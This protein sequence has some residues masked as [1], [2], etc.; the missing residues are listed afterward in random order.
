MIHYL[1]I[2]NFGPI[3]K[4]VVLDFEVSEKDESTAYEVTMPD[5]TRVLKLIY[6]YG[7]NASGKTTFLKA[8]SFLRRLFLRPVADKVQELDYSPFLFTKSPQHATT[9]FE[10]SFYIGMRYVY[11]LEL[12][13]SVITREKMIYYAS[14][15][16]TVLFERETDKTKKLTSLTFGSAIKVAAKD[17]DLLEGNT[18]HNNSVIGAFGKTNVDIPSLAIVYAYFSKFLAGVLDKTDDLIEYTAD[19]ISGD[20]N[21]KS[22]VNE[23]MHK[24]D[25]QIAAVEA[26]EGYVSVPD[27]KWDM[28]SLRY[29]T[30]YGSVRNLFGRSNA[31][32]MYG[33]GS[34]ERKVEVKHKVKDV[35]YT[36]PLSSESSGTRHYFGLA[37]P[38]YKLIHGKQILCIDELENSLHPDLMQH[39]LQLFLLNASASQLVITTHNLSLM[40]N[41]DLIR[42]DALWF[43]QKGDD[44]SVQLYSAADFDSSVLRKSSSILKAYNTGKLGAK[45]NLGSPYLGWQA[46]LDDGKKK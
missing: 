25:R 17:R 5:G 41:E 21:I 6:L 8:F 34:V 20:S 9:K 42:K 39:F 40:A 46:P 7:P 18:L 13:N 26:H 28:T 1:K 44:G 37:G 45:P 38:L 24:A 11:E 2:S 36:L 35:E 10:L 33:G 22:W 15:K 14:A 32:K 19:M 3:R 27:P 16:P 30:L 23:F 29:K 4:E 43:T 12:R 31:I